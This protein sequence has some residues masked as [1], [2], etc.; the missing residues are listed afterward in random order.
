MGNKRLNARTENFSPTWANTFRS[1]T[2]IILFTRFLLPSKRNG[3]G[4][5]RSKETKDGKS[6]KIRTQFGVTLH[7]AYF[8]FY[9]QQYKLPAAHKFSFENIHFAAYSRFHPRRTALHDLSWVL[10]YPTIMYQLRTL[11]SVD[12]AH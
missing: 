11:L 1:T 6:G 3:S 12:D 7:A 10:H 8:Y 2:V 5:Q 9:I 4:Q